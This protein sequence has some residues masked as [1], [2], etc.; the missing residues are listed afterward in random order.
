MNTELIDTG[1]T[2]DL[3]AVQIGLIRGEKNYGPFRERVTCEKYFRQS[4]YIFNEQGKYVDSGFVQI[5]DYTNMCKMIK[6]C[7]KS[8]KILHLFERWEHY[9]TKFYKSNDFSIT[10]L[11]SGNTIGSL[12]ADY[13]AEFAHDNESCFVGDLE[14]DDY[15]EMLLECLNEYSS[16]NA[17]PRTYAYLKK[18]LGDKMCDCN[19]LDKL[20]IYDLLKNGE[21]NEE[22]KQ[23]MFKSLICSCKNMPEKPE[24]TEEEKIE[25][26]ELKLQA[27][28]EIAEVFLRINSKKVEETEL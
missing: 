22:Q 21:I 23:E 5:N 16:V 20:E 4:L 12:K 8:K 2:I 11:V 15:S 3:P 17:P 14:K 26:A 10:D 1:L 13:V 24:L 9:G 25:R 19:L 28:A 18:N 6:I 27:Q 7:D